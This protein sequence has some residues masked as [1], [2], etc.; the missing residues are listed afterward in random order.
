MRSLLNA[1]KPVLL[2]STATLG[3]LAVFFLTGRLALAVACGMA[4]GIMQLG[5]ALARKQQIG[6]LQLFSVF[7][8]LASGITTLITHDPRFVLLK[9]SLFYTIAGIVMLKRGWMIRYLPP[10]A[11]QLVPDIAIGFGYAWAALMFCTAIVNIVAA[12]YF[13]ISISKTAFRSIRYSLVSHL[14]VVSVGSKK[15]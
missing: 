6:A 14:R 1:A 3:F 13:S 4:L 2:D 12:L 10:V 7:I 15:K 5:M 8:V 9:P 11:K